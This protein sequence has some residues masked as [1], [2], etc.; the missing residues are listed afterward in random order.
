MSRYLLFRLHGPMA[1]WGEVAVGE[2]RPTSD[3]PTRSAVLGLVAAALGLRREDEEPLRSLFAGYGFGCRVDSPGTLLVDYH[4]AQIAPEQALKK[5]PRPSVRA[6]ELAFHKDALSTTLSTRDYRCDALATACLW[7]R[8]EAPWTL[9]QLVEALH[10]PA[11]TLYLGR[12]SC[13]LDLP[14]APRIV[15]ADHPTTALL[16]RDEREECFLQAT[17]AAIGF[18]GLRWAFDGL[19]S[20]RDRRAR[21][22][23]ERGEHDPDMPFDQRRRRRDD[24]RSRLRWQFIERDEYVAFA[25]EQVPPG[26]KEDA[27]G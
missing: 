1:S 20:S 27:N 8:G 7:A 21:L 17:R 3:T 12:K 19:A 4:T 16:S 22:H 26:P 13:P 15:E 25:Q 6:E 5:R 9:E 24:P 14:L 11:F 23:W 18:D 10:R 2:R